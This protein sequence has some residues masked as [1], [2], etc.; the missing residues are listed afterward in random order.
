MTPSTFTASDSARLSFRFD[1]PDDAPVLVLSNSLGTAMAMWRPQMPQLRR[2]FRVLRYDSRGHGRSSSPAG[3]YSLA[4]LGQDVIELMDHAG[5]DQVAFCGLSMGG[6]I[7]Q[8][9]GANAPDRIRRLVLCNTSAF[10]GPEGWRG[11]IEAVRSGGMQAIADPVIARWFTP[12]FRAR[13]LAAVSRA[14]ALLLSQRPEGYI[15]CCAAIRDM[16]LRGST[17]A[18]RAPTLVIGGMED[19]ATPPSDSEWLAKTIPDAALVM[20]PAAHLS[21]IEC[22]RAFTR[23]VSGFLS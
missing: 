20:L 17:Q 5:I 16:D 11:R 14:R 1:G 13:R 2:R 18:I 3:E 22:S 7:G 8:W 4:R 15:G 21:N 12:D 19:Q 10:M 6:M 9:L 23:L